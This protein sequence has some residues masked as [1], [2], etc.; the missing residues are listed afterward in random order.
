MIM[1]IDWCFFFHY[2]KHIY[3]KERMCSKLLAQFAN[4]IDD[5]IYVFIIISI[6]H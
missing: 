4:V 6:N 3:D 1:I 5:M 2:D